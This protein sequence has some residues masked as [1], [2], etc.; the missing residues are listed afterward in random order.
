MANNIG[1][2]TRFGGVIL[3]TLSLR[4]T[5]EDLSEQ[6]FLIKQAIIARKYKGYKV[7]QRDE[8]WRYRSERDNWVCPTCDQL[9][10]KFSL[11]RGDNIPGLFPTWSWRYRTRRIEPNTHDVLAKDSEGQC[12]CQMYWENAPFV[13]GNLIHNDF[14]AVI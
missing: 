7:F 5:P 12:R 8:R 1:V 14:L 11:F 10:R 9:D 4:G 3:P 13:M 6:V 2:V